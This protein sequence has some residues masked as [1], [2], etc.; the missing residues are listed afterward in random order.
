M[1]I[2]ALGEGKVPTS[3]L[4]DSQWDINSVPQLFPS[5]KF[6]MFHE[7]K[8]TI[9]PQEFICSRLK[10]IDTRFQQCIP[11]SLPV[12]AIQKKNRWREI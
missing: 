12:L 1:F 10:N 11:M 8:V 6:G 5:G 7:R 3:I 2:F 9:T 4:K